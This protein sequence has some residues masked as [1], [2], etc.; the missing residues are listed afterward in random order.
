MKCS[1]NYKNS[2]A[3]IIDNSVI[4]NIVKNIIELF[5]YIECRIIYYKTDLQTQEGTIATGI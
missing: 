5:N 1:T 4:M 2:R 3:F